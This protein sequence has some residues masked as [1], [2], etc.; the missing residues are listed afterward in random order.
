MDHARPERTVLRRARTADSSLLFSSP[1]FALTALVFAAGG[2]QAR[3]HR[4][5]HGTGPRVTSQLSGSVV[6]REGGRLRLAT[7]LGN[8]IVH[9]G[10]T[11]KIDYSVELEADAGPDAKELLKEFRILTRE[12]PDGVVIKGLTTDEEECTGRLWVTIRVNMPRDYNVEV[13]TGGGNIETDDVSGRVNLF[14]AGGNISAGNIDGPARIE[15]ASGGHI[16]LKNVAG[17]LTAITGGG[18]IT[19]GSVGGNATLRTTGGHIRVGS[20]QGIARLDTGGGNITLQQSGSD[21]I[22]ETAGG[23]IEVGE[24]AGLVRART[25]G[26]GI[27]V[28]RL[29]GPTNLE[30]AGGSIYLT[31]V[32]S[33]VRAS[34]VAGGIT[35]WFVAPP[36]GQSPCEFNSNDGD[37]V[38]YLP[39]QIPVTID[40]RIQMGDDHRLIVD[41]AFPLK[42]SYDAS[43]RGE[44]MVRAEGA[45]NGGGEVIRLR[46]VAGNIRVALS[47]TNK[48]LQIQKEQMEQITRQIQA[49]MRLLLPIEPS[50]SPTPQP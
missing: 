27:R 32:D 29:S 25:G 39:R 19:T 14:T 31:Q 2:A 13:S 22:A 8:V 48:Q 44:R 9:T 43:A 3:T 37:I 33:S 36:K 20:V 30:T 35:A 11:A 47:D 49:Q 45:L 34:A 15:S 23:Q 7:Q 41:P 1:I 16:S 26:G 5:A 24:A 18:H 50:G 46:T 42:V 28:V 10:D 21:L 40:A 38:V 4:P 12:V 17:D 6:A